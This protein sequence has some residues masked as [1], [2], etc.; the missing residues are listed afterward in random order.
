[1]VGGCSRS[2]GAKA[3]DWVWVVDG[4][5]SLRFAAEGTGRWLWRVAG[6]RWGFYDA[7]E[8][9]RIFGMDLRGAWMG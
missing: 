6:R 8:L 2:P 4:F 5:G 1:M 9:R 7:C 3:E